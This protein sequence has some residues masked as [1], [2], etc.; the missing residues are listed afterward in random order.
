MSKR[1]IINEVRRGE[2]KKYFDS[3]YVSS[4]T[5]APLTSS[6]F[7]QI[8]SD[9]PQ[10]TSDTKRIGSSICMHSCEIRYTVHWNENTGT[11]PYYDFRMGFFIWNS[12]TTPTFADIYQY[13]D[14]MVSPYNHDQKVLRKIVYD[15]KHQVYLDNTTGNTWI[16]VHMGD[17]YIDWRFRKD[18]GYIINFE[19]TTTTGIGH[20]Y[21]ILYS[22]NSTGATAPTV[23]MLSRINYTD[24]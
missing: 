19:G 4:P 17:K 13:T 10:G 8:L 9:V 11:N 5:N 1:K 18:G 12:D 6:G 7:I 16:P 2:E 3:S 21:C 23:T 15:C 22:S 20:L 14:A 24:T